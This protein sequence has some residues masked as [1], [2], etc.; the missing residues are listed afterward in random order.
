MD[1]E[2]RI[3]EEEGAF[4]EVIKEH[5]KGAGIKNG[6][7]GQM[8]SLKS[9]IRSLNSE[10]LHLEGFMIPKMANKKPIFISVPNLARS[11]KANQ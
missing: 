5:L 11:V 2:I 9:D 8:V 4:V 1:D 7:K 6:E 3:N 10:A